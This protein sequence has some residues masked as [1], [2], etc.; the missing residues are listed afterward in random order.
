[1]PIFNSRQRYLTMGAFDPRRRYL[2]GRGM[3]ILSPSYRR[4][5]AYLGRM[6]G[7]LGQD[8]IDEDYGGSGI[9]PD[10][11]ILAAQSASLSVPTTMIPEGDS[12]LTAPALSPISLTPSVGTIVGTISNAAGQIVPAIVNS[13]GV[14]VPQTTASS[15]LTGTLFGFPTWA[16]LAVAGLA[17]VAASS[18]GGRR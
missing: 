6:G 3:G 8:V 16:I 2:T 12:G 1:M 13:A 4:K 5:L 15:L 7:R 10:A 14:V 11:A 17:V 18:G 9:D